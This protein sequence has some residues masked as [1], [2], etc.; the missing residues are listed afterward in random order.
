MIY[1]GFP[2]LILHFYIEFIDERDSLIS[3][4]LSPWPAKF[5]TEGQYSID[6]ELI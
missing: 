2:K 6:I 1:S 3:I 4:F 5:L